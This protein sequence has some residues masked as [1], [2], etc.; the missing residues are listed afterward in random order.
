MEDSESIIY[1]ILTLF[2]EMNTFSHV[3]RIKIQEGT[4]L[5]MR[6]GDV[7][8]RPWATLANLAMLQQL[9]KLFRLFTK[10]FCF[11]RRFLEDNSIQFT[12]NCEFNRYT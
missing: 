5:R 12:V 3:T 10:L 9:Y 1:E 11:N 8:K 7:Y 2:M 6:K 4:V